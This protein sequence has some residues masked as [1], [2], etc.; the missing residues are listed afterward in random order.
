MLKAFFISASIAVSGL[1]CV[2]PALALPVDGGLVRSVGIGGQEQRLRVHFRRHRYQP[3][4][5]RRCLGYP[6]TFYP[7]VHPFAEPV[8]VPYVYGHFGR[9]R[10]NHR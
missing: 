10:R 9:Q 1:I 6:Y 7:F 8:Y 3:H 4:V 5:H 2:H